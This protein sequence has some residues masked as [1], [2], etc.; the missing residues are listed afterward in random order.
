MQFPLISTILLLGYYSSIFVSANLFENR[1]QRPKCD[2]R[3]AKSLILHKSRPKPF[4]SSYFRAHGF[5]STHTKTIT[6]TVR[7]T[8]ECS[9]IVVQTFI[10]GETNTNFDASVTT[11]LPRVTITHYVSTVVVPT[12]TTRAVDRREIRKP[13]PA[14]RFCCEKL[15]DCPV[16]TISAACSQITRPATVTKTKTKTK[17]LTIG[18]TDTVTFT[19]TTFPQL[20]ITSGTATVYPG[21]DSTTVNSVLTT[22][23]P[24]QCAGQLF[25]PPDD[26]GD[27]FVEELVYPY[28]PQS[29]L[30]CCTLCYDRVNCI[31]SAWIDGGGNLGSCQHLLVVSP[32][33]GGMVGDKCPLGV[34]NVPFTVDF[35]FGTNVFP[36]PC[37]V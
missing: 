26:I 23:V 16:R 33:P 37:G 2:V 10:A 28:F 36:G 3:C 11:T 29:A 17:T 7:V 22:S 15:S 12:G 6:R 25:T 31:A 8:T 5:L 30:E 24:A 13:A 21:P 34:Q 27:A 19:F 4:C 32:Q 14:P 18:C 20:S 1:N 9:T 35:D